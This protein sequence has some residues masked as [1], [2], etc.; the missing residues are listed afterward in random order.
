MVLGDAHPVGGKVPAPTSCWWRPPACAA[1]ARPYVDGGLGIVVVEATVRH[2]F[3][4]KIGPILSFANIA[5]VTK[6]DRGSQAERE[7]FR[8][9]IME[10]RLQVRIREVNALYGIGIIRSPTPDRNRAGDSRRTLTA[11]Q[12]CKVGASADLR[13]QKQPSAGNRISAWC[14]RW[15]TKFCTGANDVTIYFDNTATTPVDPRVAEAMALARR[16]S[17]IPPACTASGA[18]RARLWRAREKV[19]ALIGARAKEIVFVASGTEAD[20]LAIA[21]A[22]GASPPRRDGIVV[23][24]IE[25][26]AVLETAKALRDRGAAALTLAPMPTA[27]PIPWFRAMSPRRP[28]SSR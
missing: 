20:N 5:V 19:A 8:A 16:A 10:A 23:S 28:A 12:S 26:P 1:A 14:G 4:R 21:G 2:E 25:H 7:V 6:I 17:A 22:V 15:K 18:P 13:R 9:R 3:P 11:R 27:S 24:A